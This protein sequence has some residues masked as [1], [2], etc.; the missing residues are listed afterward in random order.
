MD[1]FKV[2]L[3]LYYLASLDEKNLAHDFKS[4]FLDIE[5]TICFTISKGRIFNL[6]AEIDG[7]KNL[8]SSS[9]SCRIQLIS[10]TFNQHYIISIIPKI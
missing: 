6:D 3:L 10:E 4:P 5:I 7:Y 9:S 8:P 2:T 1:T